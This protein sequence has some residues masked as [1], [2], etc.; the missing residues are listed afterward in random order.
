MPVRISTT[1]TEILSHP[2]EF[3]LIIDKLNYN[4]YKKSN[5]NNGDQYYIYFINHIINIYYFYFTSLDILLGYNLD[6]LGDSGQLKKTGLA[7]DLLE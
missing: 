2:I 5:K 4:E 7:M 1:G 6:L 3:L